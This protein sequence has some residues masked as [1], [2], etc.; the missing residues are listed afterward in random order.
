[1]GVPTL[2]KD[3]AYLQAAADYIRGSL[4]ARWRG[5]GGGGGGG[6]GAGGRLPQLTLVQR[7]NYASEMRLTH[8]TIRNIQQVPCPLLISSPTI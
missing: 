1:V 7:A 3:T 2:C 6:G 5:G 8:G 4:G